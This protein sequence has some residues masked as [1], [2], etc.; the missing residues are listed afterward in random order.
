[1]DTEGQP[2]DTVSE[3]LKS[4]F[5]ITGKNQQHDFILLQARTELLANLQ[6]VQYSGTQLLPEFILLLQNLK[7][8]QTPC[9]PHKAINKH[10]PT[11]RYDLS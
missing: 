11:H 8:S 4:Q 10:L 1:M 3:A 2:D 6:L 5:V 9:Q 7:A